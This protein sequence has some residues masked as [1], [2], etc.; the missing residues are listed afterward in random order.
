MTKIM[1]YTLSLVIW[2]SHCLPSAVLV[3]RKLQSRQRSR[4]LFPCPLSI[5][6]CPIFHQQRI[7]L[8][9]TILPPPPHMATSP[10]SNP[11][12]LYPFDRGVCNSMNLRTFD[13]ILIL[14]QNPWICARIREWICESQPESENESVNQ[15]Q[16]PWIRIHES[17]SVNLGQNPW[18]NIWN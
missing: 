14:G 10:S 4:G 3:S 1:W 13:R 16:N 7:S 12:S 15:G 8:R 11:L 6:P 9:E 18:M 5:V 2:Y 17:E